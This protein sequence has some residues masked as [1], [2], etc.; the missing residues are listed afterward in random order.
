MTPT[1]KDAKGNEWAIKLNGPVIKDIQDTFKFKLTSLDADPINQLANDPVMLVDVLFLLCETQAKE[2]Q[3]DSRAFG[4]ILEP[5]LDG[6]IAALTEALINFFPS[7]KRSAIRSALLA[8]QK[9][10]DKAAEIMINELGSPEMM[11][12]MEAKLR[13]RGKAEID[14]LLNQ[15]LTNTL[16]TEEKPSATS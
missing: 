1:F 6:P 12:R 3:L 4:E 9:V 11:N 7:G 10:Q 13:E 16:S 2:R 15:D 8:S 14:R 5:G